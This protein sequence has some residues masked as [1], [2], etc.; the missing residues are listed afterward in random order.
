M[1]FFQSLIFR[2]NLI[3]LFLRC[4]YCFCMVSF[5]FYIIFCCF[6]N[7]CFLFCLICR[8]FS[9][10]FLCFSKR[11]RC[12]LIN[13]SVL[14]HFH[15][16]FFS[17]LSCLIHLTIVNLYSYISLCSTSL[18]QLI[19]LFSCFDWLAIW[20]ISSCICGCNRCRL[21]FSDFICLYTISCRN[22]QSSKS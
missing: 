7:S 22:S 6:F 4:F 19:L 5:C 9:L 2:N 3:I 20:Q 1:R 15:T 14:H 21:C 17:C 8:N 18:I 12:P 13:G 10:R 11:I 16:F